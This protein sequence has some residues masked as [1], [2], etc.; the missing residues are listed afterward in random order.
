MAVPGIPLPPPTGTRRRPA[1][2]ALAAESAAL[3]ERADVWWRPLLDERALRAY[4]RRWTLSTVVHVVWF[5]TPGLVLLAI[6]P[7]TFPLALVCAGFA[8]VVPEL[9]ASRGA[10]VA[11]PRPTDA[12]PGAE[13]HALGMLGDL[14]GHQGRERYA[15]TG[16][17]LE[18]GTLGVWLIGD[19]G[20]LLVRERGRSVHCFCVRVPHRS[21]PRGDRAAHLLLALRADER[22]FA[23]VANRA[24]AGARWRVRRRLPARMRPA[25]DDA[26]HLARRRSRDG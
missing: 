5:L 21:L 17:V 18:R 11:R 8:W 15:R 24:F 20:A 9:Y 23:T 6:E 22:A 2:E 10:K 14:I 19:A 26:T 16:L 13:R 1:P 3:P 4:A 12:G 25:L 7:L